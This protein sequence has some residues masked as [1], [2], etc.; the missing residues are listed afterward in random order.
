MHEKQEGGKWR[1]KFSKVDVYIS[2][3]PCVSDMM[4]TRWLQMHS[5]SKMTRGNKKLISNTFNNSHSSV[6][7]TFKIPFPIQVSLYLM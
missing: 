1:S 5:Q 4:G 2:G 7:L 6:Q 3:V